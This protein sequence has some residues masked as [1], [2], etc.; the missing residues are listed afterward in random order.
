MYNRQREIRRALESC[1]AQDFTDFEIVVVDDASDDDS[2]AAASAYCDL[3]IKVVCHATNRGECPA[4]NTGVASSRGEWIVFL[5]SD[6]A[7]M[8]GSLSVIHRYIVQE[9]EDIG[10]L[11][12]MFK[13]DTGECSPDPAPDCSVWDYEGWLR[14]AQTA[15][16]SDT[17]L[18]TRHS[19]F[20]TVPLTDSRVAP[21]EYNLEFAHNFK[22]RLIPVVLA[23]QYTDSANR[24]TANRVRSGRAS[25]LLRA[26]DDVASSER[27]LRNHGNALRRHAPRPYEVIYRRLVLANFVGGKWFVGVR[28][29]FGYLWSCRPTFN[30]LAS[31]AVAAVWPTAFLAARDWKARRA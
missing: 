20:R 14:F 30:G 8:P 17:L 15:R 22:T 2:V 28:L 16:L 10:R 1:L 24:L 21:T 9:S 7:L 29:A 18:C 23:I 25:I 11:G 26:S 19:T 12:F 5:D 31:I 27:M 13:F 4:R 6:H 3:R